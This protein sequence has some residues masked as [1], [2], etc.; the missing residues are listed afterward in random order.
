MTNT[1]QEATQSTELSFEE[2]M[3][4]THGY[5]KRKAEP[6]KPV[7]HITFE[8]APH[9]GVTIMTHGILEI[10]T[11]LPPQ[12]PHSIM[13]LHTTGTVQILGETLDMLA[14]HLR[15]MQIS[16]LV[17]GEQE[18]GGVVQKIVVNGGLYRP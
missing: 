1:P 14:M 2:Y 4:K 3:E 12:Q 17:A 11:T 5:G 8:H 13:L 16:Y 9:Q 18:G 15:N 7:A 10:Q 6:V